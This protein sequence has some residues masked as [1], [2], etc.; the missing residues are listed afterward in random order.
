[1]ETISILI[2]GI[3]TLPLSFGLVNSTLSAVF[4]RLVP[5]ELL[6]IRSLEHHL[7]D[8]Q[9]KSVEQLE[10]NLDDSIAS[11]LHDLNNKAVKRTRSVSSYSGLNLRFETSM[12]SR[13][14]AKSR[15]Q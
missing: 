2:T 3:D 10:E 1:M 15:R 6:P 4:S 9:F 8:S 12:M 7:A 13:R 5:F 14:P 11:K